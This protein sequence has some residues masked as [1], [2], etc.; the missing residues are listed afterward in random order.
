MERHGKQSIDKMKKIT[1]IAL[2]LTGFAASAQSAKDTVK[3]DT[4][5]QIILT[6]QQFNAFLQWLDGLNESHQAVKAAQT[7]FLNN[8]QLTL[9][10]KKR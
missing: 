7:L 8:A 6:Q 10:P 9:I 2:L 5:V 3:K 1:F 4:A